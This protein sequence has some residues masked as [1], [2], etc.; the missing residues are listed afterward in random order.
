MKLPN[1][2]AMKINIGELLLKAKSLIGLLGLIIAFS[3]LS[4]RFLDYYNLT[5]VLRQTSLNAIMAVGMTFVIL[6]GGIDLSV[7]SILAFSSAVTAGML[8]DGMPLIIA[9]LAGL[10]I[11]TGL[12]L[13]NGF[14][15]IR[16]NIPPFIA[17][18]AM[19]TIARGLTL[20]YTNGQ[21]IT[22]LGKAFGYIGNGYVGSIPV[23]IIITI[24]VFVIG[25]YILKNNRLGRYVYATGGNLQAAKL[26]GINTNKIILFVYAL[27]GFLAAVSGLIITSRLNSAAPT[28][29][30]GAELDAIAAV[31]LGGTSLSGGEGGIIGTLI[32]ALIIGVLNN[33][34]NLLN[35]SP[36]YQYIVKGVVILLAIALDKKESE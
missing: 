24:L 19:M 20:V 34:L 23:P 14:V 9:L 15:I 35:V 25:Y 13:F 22:G 28:A 8:K 3:I 29:G 31:V 30:Q 6:T 17:T 12:G 5:N 36:F 21:P 10:I 26:A 2:K 16:W 18:F 27:S 11:G 7:G 33:G 32:G 1:E 4:P